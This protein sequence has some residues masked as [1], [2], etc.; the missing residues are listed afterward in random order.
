ME[1]DR[2]RV[3]HR[4]HRARAQAHAGVREEGRLDQRHGDLPDACCDAIFLRNVYHHITQV[5]SFNKSLLAS[6]KPGGRLAIIDF[7]PEKGSKLFPGVPANREGHGVPIA[8]VEAELPAAGFT[9]VK[10][11]EKWPAGDKTPPFLVL[12]KKP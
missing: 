12:F 2:P 5:E 9:H 11:A 6:L 7:R 10:T 4:H 8:V 1:Y 3:C